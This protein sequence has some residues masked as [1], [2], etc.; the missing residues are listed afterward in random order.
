MGILQYVDKREFDALAAQVEALITAEPDWAKLGAML[1]E[2][3]TNALKLQRQQHIAEIRAEAVEQF[4]EWLCGSPAFSN[5]KQSLL[6]ICKH[7]NQYTHSIRQHRAS[8]TVATLER[9]I[10]PGHCHA[11]ADKVYP[12]DYYTNIDGK[13]Y[14]DGCISESAKHKGGA[15]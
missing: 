12:D 11:C 4:A 9:I 14:H 2:K 5:K 10:D 8:P 7:T 3:Q 6:S 13:L 1:G 15:K